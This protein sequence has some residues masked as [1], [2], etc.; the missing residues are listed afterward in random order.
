[1]EQKPKPDGTKKRRNP[2][3]NH[4][5]G[6]GAVQPLRPGSGHHGAD[7]GGGGYRQRDAVQLFP[8]QRSHHQCLL[9]QTFQDRN[10][11]RLEQLRSLPDTRS[12]LTAVFRFLIDGVQAQKEIFEA[13]MVYRMK[14]VISFDP[15]DDGEQTGLSHLDP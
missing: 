11:D 3:Q 9:Q 4:R 1:M 15:V 13:F 14:K 12:R 5:R 8:L 7:R 2:Q 6:G 10:D